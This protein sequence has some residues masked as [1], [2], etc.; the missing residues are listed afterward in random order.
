MTYIKQY[1]RTFAVLRQ[2]ER[3]SGFLTCFTNEAVFARNSDNGL[4]SS[5]RL[6][7]PIHHLRIVLFYVQLIVLNFVIKNKHEPKLP[8]SVNTPYSE[9]LPASDILGFGA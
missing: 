8:T 3:S 4:I 6:I 5:S 9:R 7:L 2:H 1:Y